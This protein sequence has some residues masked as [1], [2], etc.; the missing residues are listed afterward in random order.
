MGGGDRTTFRQAG[1]VE[2][3]PYPKR[4]KTLPEILTMQETLTLFVAI[5]SVNYKAIL[6][7]A[8]SAGLRILEVCAL[9]RTDIECFEDDYNCL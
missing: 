6:A 5:Q 2:H 9:K 7:T 4:P 3:L 1:V 8:Y